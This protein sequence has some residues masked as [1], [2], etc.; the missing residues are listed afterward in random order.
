MEYGGV[1]LMGTDDIAERILRAARL[2]QP[3]YAA[4][5]WTWGWP[6]RNAHVPTVEEIADT[7]KGLYDSAVASPSGSS[8]SGRLSVWMDEDDGSI[9]VDVHLAELRD[10]SDDA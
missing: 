4:H 3:I 8:S 6:S 1:L 2:A 7:I 10:A 9:S 5:G